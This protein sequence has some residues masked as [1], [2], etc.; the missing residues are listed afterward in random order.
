ME[1]DNLSW[2]NGYSQRRASKLGIGTTIVLSFLVALVGGVLGSVIY[3]SSTAKPNATSSA[4][5]STKTI[6]S[7]A[8]AVDIAEPSVVDVETESID[9][10]GNLIGEA[11]S[12][13]IYSQDGY[14]ITN[15][16]VISRAKKIDVT[17]S[18][19]K[20][21][22]ATVVAA[23]NKNDIA[24]LKID[25]NDLTPAKFSDSSTLRRGEE[26]FVIGNPLGELS[27]TV[28]DGII[29]AE[30]REIELDGTKMSLIQTNAEINSGNS[31][32]GMFRLS[33]ELIGIV[34]AK[35]AGDDLEGLA[36][37]IPA[38]KVKECV[39]SLLKKI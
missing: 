21:Y 32:G 29:S 22:P 28:T 26:I 9:A 7:I 10:K 35:T 20:I 15:K 3:N 38:N 19:G 39:E 25:A 13:V 36:F 5:V 30:N 27:G 31:G 17:L 2:N 23:D 6:G 4:V 8:D 12:G 33:G 11:G 37:V 1:K 18:N 34:I 14:I 24:I 16:H